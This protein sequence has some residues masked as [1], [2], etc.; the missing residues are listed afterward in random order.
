MNKKIKEKLLNMKQVF[1]YIKIPEDAKEVDK[2]INYIEQLEQE[3]KELREQLKESNN[4]LINWE[5]DF[6]CDHSTGIC[7]CELK[8]II[9]RNNEL[10]NKRKR[11][12]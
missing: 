7:Y 5:K 12:L 2:I 10:L 11:Q 3:K 1:I 4:E 9:Y 8:S 6:Q